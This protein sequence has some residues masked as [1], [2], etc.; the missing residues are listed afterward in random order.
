M[1]LEQRRLSSNTV[2]PTTNL[3]RFRLFNLISR[4]EIRFLFLLSANQR[5]AADERPDQ[6][7]QV[8]RDHAPHNHERTNRVLGDVGGGEGSA[9]RDFVLARA[10]RC[11]HEETHGDHDALRGNECHV[12]NRQTNSSRERIR[13]QEV[14]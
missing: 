4:L 1:S 8:I 7:V 10:A 5:R 12:V 9:Q 3:K 13:G 14:R 6:Q 2:Q 11:R